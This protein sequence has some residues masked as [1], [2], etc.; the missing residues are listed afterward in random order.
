MLAILG[1]AM[2]NAELVKLTL[3]SWKWESVPVYLVAYFA[4]GVGIVVSALVAAVNQV[5]QRLTLS[6]ARKEIRHLKEE[7]SQLRRAALD[8]ALLDEDETEPEILPPIRGGGR[9]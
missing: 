6:K 8:D 5:Q 1:F 9:S 7:L 4:F 2:Q 3:W